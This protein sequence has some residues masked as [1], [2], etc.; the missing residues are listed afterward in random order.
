MFPWI[1]L[2]VQPDGEVLP[3]C[4]S[5]SLNLNLSNKNLQEIWNSEEIKT[6]RL[7]MLNDIKSPTC[8]YCYTSEKIGQESPRQ[9]INEKY[10]HHLN[11]VKTTSDD[12]KVDKLNIV[13]W[14]FRYSNIC[15]F[16][17]RMCGPMNST[18]WYKDFNSL[19][20]V[21]YND[22][23]ATKNNILKE[24]NPL[25]DIVEEIYFAGGEPLIMDEHYY[26]LDKLI[27]LKKTDIPIVYSTNLSILRYKDKNI[28]DIWK[29]FENISLGI[30]LDGSGKRGEL[31]RNGLKWDV[32]LQNL[33]SVRKNLPKARC[34]IG[35]TYQALNCFNIMET[36]KKLFESGLLSS[37]DDFV[38]YFLEDPNFLSVHILDKETKKVLSDKI[39]EHINEFLIPCESITSIT[40]YKNMI[41]YINLEDKSY[42]IPQFIKYCNS[43]DFIR[44]ENTRKT[45]PELENLW[46]YESS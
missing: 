29:N 37:V 45:F 16:K 46:N 39:N 12:G 25:F 26:I 43:L 41:K 13:Y 30:S 9:R 14:D 38:V 42:L 10:K 32:F 18:S 1:H 11:I 22:G 4:T 35:V 15:N 33:N 24:L 34:I 6:L 3:C 19:M 31:I 20:D 2:S 28:L 17:C 21:N 7:N 27:Q 40:D 23:K 5:Y 44:N 8:E 36:Q